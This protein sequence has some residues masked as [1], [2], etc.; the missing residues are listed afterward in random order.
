M[1]AGNLFRTHWYLEE[2]CDRTF[3]AWFGT[4]LTPGLSVH[5]EISV[6]TIHQTDY[7][8]VLVCTATREMASRPTDCFPWIETLFVETLVI[9]EKTL[10]VGEK[11]PSSCRICINKMARPVQARAHSKNKCNEIPVRLE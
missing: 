7:I 8:L 10:V 6:V 1:L 9:G 11:G 4:A 5:V 3:V 2:R